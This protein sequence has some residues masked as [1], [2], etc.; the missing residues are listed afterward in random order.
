MS[1]VLLLDPVYIFWLYF[2]CGIL[3]NVFI[4][5]KLVNEGRVEYHP[6]SDTISNVF[7]EKIVMLIFWPLR[8]FFFLS[9]TTLIKI[10]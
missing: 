4:I 8:Y 1:F 2:G 5:R 7:G 6:L 3:L 10:I 9:Q